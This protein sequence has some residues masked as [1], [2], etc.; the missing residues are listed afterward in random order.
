MRNK[1]LEIAKQYSKQYN[2]YLI[3]LKSLEFELD[4]I[5]QESEKERYLRQYMDFCV[6]GGM[7][8]GYF[9]LHYTSKHKEVKELKAKI[10]D[11]HLKIRDIKK[12]TKQAFINYS[13]TFNNEL[14]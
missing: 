1:L 4:Y 7:S 14:F 3:K 13:K 9:D 6:D 11:L 12:K 10:K 5:N 2:D 8:E